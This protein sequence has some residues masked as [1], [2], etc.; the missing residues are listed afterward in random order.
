[1][2]NYGVICDCPRI[3]RVFSLMVDIHNHGLFDVDDGAATL[4][5]AVRMLR[6]AKQQGVH[7][8][9]L[10]PH[11]RHGMFKYRREI[12]EA[13]FADLKEEAEQMGMDIYLGCEYHVNSRILE[14]LESGRCLPM[15]G[16][17]FVLTEYAYETPYSYILNWTNELLHHGY[18]PIIA[19]VER[20]E[21][22]FLYPDRVKEL[23][24]M[25]AYIQLNADSVTGKHGMK[26][27]RFC[28]QMLQE[29][30][31]AVMVASDAHD[32]EK[33]RS[34]MGECYD[35]ILRKHGER[36][37]ELVMSENPALVIENVASEQI[38]EY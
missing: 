21:S 34:H 19:H 7:A 3:E 31:R 20:Y 32:L 17:S 13:Q 8:V 5:E 26:V 11:Y 15:A 37:A 2:R 22:I 25:G 36:T 27:K 14:Y 35:F 6:E 38:Q 4:R 16:G 30:K 23:I 10:T 24:R 18:I 1:M 29:N 33:R 9:V 12:I 28:K